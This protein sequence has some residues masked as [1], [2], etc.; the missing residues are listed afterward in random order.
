MYVKEIKFLWS[1]TH[2][3]TSYVYTLLQRVHLHFW[4]FDV[5][6]TTNCA[7]DSL[8]ITDIDAGNVT[9]VLCGNN[10]PGDVMSSGNGLSV[11]FM[12][13]SSVTKN[14]FVITYTARTV[15]PGM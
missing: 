1:S 9:Y 6:E 8:I 2:V 3:P 15:M 12:T 11:V 7:N 10:L 5:Q 13:D 14:G 4:R